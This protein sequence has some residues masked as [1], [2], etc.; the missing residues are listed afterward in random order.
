MGTRIS[1]V[2]Y[3]SCI[4]ITVP[5]TSEEETVIVYPVRKSGRLVRITVEAGDAVT[6]DGPK[7]LED[8]D[9]LR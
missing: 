7:C 6:V 3:G 8:V 2:R 1:D 4:V 5:P 9:Y